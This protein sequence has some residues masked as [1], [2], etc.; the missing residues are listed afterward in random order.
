MKASQ[1]SSPSALGSSPLSR[2]SRVLWQLQD[3]I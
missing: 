1:V 2:L 3:S